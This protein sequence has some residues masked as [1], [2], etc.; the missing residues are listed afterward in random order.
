MNP[1]LQ[2]TANTARLYV[3]ERD[4]FL[5][6]LSGK[7]GVVT[8]HHPNCIIPSSRVPLNELV[9]FLAVRER[10]YMTERMSLEL[11]RWVQNAI[12]RD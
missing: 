11:E 10:K 5:V 8:F 12:G 4:I 2:M 9:A 6:K 1:T 3:G 7:K